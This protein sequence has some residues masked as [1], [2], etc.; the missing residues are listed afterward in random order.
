MYSRFPVYSI[1][2]WNE[3]LMKKRH[4]KTLNMFRK[5]SGWQ[6]GSELK[7]VLLFRFSLHYLFVYWQT[8]LNLIFAHYINGLSGTITLYSI[9][10]YSFYSILFY[11][12]LFCSV[13]M[14]IAVFQQPTT[15]ALMILL[16]YCHC[17]KSQHWHLQLARKKQ[18]L[19]CSTSRMVWGMKFSKP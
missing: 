8:R 18:Q 7:W 1:L 3:K 16:I 9:L 4:Q 5:K 6:G 14:I 17:R 12:I 19:C 13:L 2:T 10:F 15:N 11:C